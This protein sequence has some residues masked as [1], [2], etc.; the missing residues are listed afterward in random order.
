MIEIGRRAE[1]TSRVGADLLDNLMVVRRV[2][3][4]HVVAIHQINFARLV[5][6]HDQVR[7]FRAA[8]FIRQQQRA[9]R[10]EIRVRRLHLRLV[11]RREIIRHGEP[12]AGRGKFHE[13]VAVIAAVAQRTGRR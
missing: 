7:M 6:A 12:V 8:H 13:A 3:T 1:K 5:A 11:E 9:A 4:A 2:V 10:P